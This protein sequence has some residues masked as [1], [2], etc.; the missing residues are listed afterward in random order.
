MIKKNRWLLPKRKLGKN[1]AAKQND[2][3]AEHVFLTI[4]IISCPAK[5]NTLWRVFYLNQQAGCFTFLRCC[6][7]IACDIKVDR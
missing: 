7:A 5:E 4:K 6:F 3:K 1:T 2:D